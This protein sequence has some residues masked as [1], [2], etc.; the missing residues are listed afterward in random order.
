MVFLFFPHFSSPF[1]LFFPDRLAIPLESLESYLDSRF[2]DSL[3]VI[4]I[5][6]AGYL[7]FH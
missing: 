3:R 6:G 4:L 1:L 2:G 7:M 5:R